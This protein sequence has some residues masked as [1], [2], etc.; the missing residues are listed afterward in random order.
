MSRPKYLTLSLLIAGVVLALP[1]AASAR[2]GNC[3]P[4]QPRPVCHIWTGKVTFV[5]D[6]D[7]MYVNI[8][9]VGNKRVRIT[10]INAQEQ[11]SYSHVAS[12]R[13]GE[14]HA[15]AATNYLGSLIRQGHHRVRLLAQYPSSHSGPRPRR[16]IQ[17]QIG[18]RWVDVATA[19]LRH[20]DVL[21]LPNPREW[22]WNAEYNRLSQEAAAKKIRLWNPSGC[23]RGPAANV[24]VWVNWHAEG[25]SINGEWMRIKNDDQTRPLKLGRWVA[26]TSDLRRY[27]FPSGTTVA[28]GATLTL[29]VGHGRNTRTDRFWG[30]GVS[31]FD[32]VTHDATA[33][34]DGGYLFDPRGNLRAYMI[35][36]CRV[37]CA[38]P[39]QGRASVNAFPDE[40]QEYVTVRNTSSG[41]ID[42]EG[43][44]VSTR[45]HLYSFGAHSVV[46]PGETM[47]IYMQGSARN[48]T[49][50]VKHWGFSGNILSNAGDSIALR[51]YS[52]V[53][54][55]C[56]S[57]GVG[58][59]R[60][61]P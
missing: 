10:G 49:A 60:D 2:T 52:D 31:I 23:G 57:W 32:N 35:Y 40:R 54:L 27:R 5:A 47:R 11:T 1:P 30:L 48:D 6:G 38:D 45:Y 34:G 55:S 39:L 17:T 13:H 50:L 7:T 59:C 43:Y 37:N 36:P 4:G 51:T 21:W 19:L 58:S 22:A 15:V 26:R 8:N 9:G 14:C 56:Y 44:Q 20:G 24:R 61:Q 18:G 42:L 29:H 25:G 41:P 16:S 46:G 3:V 33:R 28:P 12:R 53:I